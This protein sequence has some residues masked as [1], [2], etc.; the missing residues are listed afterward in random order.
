LRDGARTLSG[1]RVQDLAVVAPQTVVGG[2]AQ[3]QPD[4]S[5][6]GALELQ[7][8]VLRSQPGSPIL[9]PC[10]LTHRRSPRVVWET[11]QRLDARIADEW[12]R[13]TRADAC[14]PTR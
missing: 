14:T 2:V 9:I 13:L 8:N 12:A 1:Y 5:R 6:P 7:G 10:A 3:A 11:G 4:R